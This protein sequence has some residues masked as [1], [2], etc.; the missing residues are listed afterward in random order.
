MA[1]QATELYGKLGEL[2]PD[3]LIAGLEIT[4]IIKGVVLGA[5]L[6]FV[7]RGTV[8]GLKDDG[9]CAPVDSEAQDGSETPYAIL[10]Y[11]VATDGTLTSAA[12]AYFTGVFN[13]LALVFGGDDTIATHEG[14]LRKLGIFVKENIPY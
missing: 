14:A 1:N 9:S 8:L 6:G 7:A 2:T 11:G 12:E 13:A 4:P 3:N 10:A 5:D